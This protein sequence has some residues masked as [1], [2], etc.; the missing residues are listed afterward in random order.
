MEMSHEKKEKLAS[1]PY[2][3]RN[4]LPISRAN[5][6]ERTLFSFEATCRERNDALLIRAGRLPLQRPRLHA[7][8]LHSTRIHTIPTSLRR[9]HRQPSNFGLVL[10]PQTQRVPP[11]APRTGLALSLQ[12]QQHRKTR[13]K[14]RATSDASFVITKSTF[15]KSSRGS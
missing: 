4:C 13:A 15:G 11:S 9:L 12:S 6:P 2:R 8:T 14:K 10:A 3:R 1:S 5:T 7:S